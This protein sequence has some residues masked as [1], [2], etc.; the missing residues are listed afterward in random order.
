LYRDLIDSSK[1]VIIACENYED[2]AFYGAENF[3]VLYIYMGKVY[4]FDSI[5]EFEKQIKEI[6]C[7]KYLISRKNT[8]VKLCFENGKYCFYETVVSS[9]NEFVKLAD[10]CVKKRKMLDKNKKKE[11]RKKRDTWIGYFPRSTK[12]KTKYSRKK[13]HKGKE[14]E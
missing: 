11:E 10:E 3:K 8:L 9:K 2:I 6:E 4:K 13:K 12:D 5:T 14:E 1:S 7:L